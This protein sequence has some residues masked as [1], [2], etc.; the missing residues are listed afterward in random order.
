MTATALRAGVKLG[1]FL[2]IAALA[3]THLGTRALAAPGDTPTE[4]IPIDVDGRFAGAVAPQSARWY[5]F[6][7][8]GGT[9]V[10]ITLAYQPATS[11][12]VGLAVYTGDAANPRTEELLIQRRDNTVSAVW[13]DPNGRDVFLQVTN[14]GPVTSIGFV[15]TITPT[16]ALNS[17][18]GAISL[19]PTSTAPT[20]TTAVDALT[21]QGD[22]RFAGTLQPRQALWYRF[23][24][25]N[26]GANAVIGVGFTP[27]GTS[28]DLN[29]YTGPDVN[30]LTAQGGTPSR[31]APTPTQTPTNTSTATPTSA[32]PNATASLTPTPTAPSLGAETLSRTVNLPTA[33]WVYLTVV[34]NNDG[35]L[36]AFGGTVNPAGIPPTLSPTPTLTA[37]PTAT[38][39]ATPTPVVQPAPRVP[40]DAR[41]FPETRF[42]IDNDAIWGYF[43]ARGGVDVFG[44]PVSRTF[45][46]LGCTT[47]VLQRQV[48]QVCVD[49][50]PRLINLLDPEIFPYTQVNGSTFPPPDQGLKS[51][52]PKVDDPNYSTTILDFVRANAPDTVN[53]RPVGFGRTFF[54][55]VQPGRAGTDDPGILGL[56]ALEIWGAPI[57]RPQ[58]EPTNPNF[59]YQ[60]FQRGIMHYD[61]TT[62]AT[63]GILLADYLKSILTAQNLP[64]DLRQQAQGNRLFGQY[65]PGAPMWLAR[66]YE[67]PGTDLT[68]AFEPG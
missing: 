68:F 61:A 30:T 14:T 9:P 32:T 3:A 57:S 64:N 63:R 1:A 25:A 33:Q 62:G 27:A 59:I 36:L 47:Q 50:Q 53:D 8:R 49:G 19:T 29:L 23:W 5:R 2:V 12:S 55:S 13:S 45:T 34:N 66:P 6:A 44:F 54:G 40:H 11:A 52:T 7:Y 51:Q 22:G 16:G 18:G 60:R 21:I 48:A 28:T 58:T 17:P 4:A 56:L 10:T 43:Q 20:G 37:T 24:Y 35:T 46:F 42:R 39:T 41:Y 31:T 67:L 26:P 38:S 15:G 65:S